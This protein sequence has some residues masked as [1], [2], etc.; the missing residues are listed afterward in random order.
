MKLKITKLWE[1]INGNCHLNKANLLQGNQFRFQS[2]IEPC[3]CRNLCQTGGS[4]QPT[5]QLYPPKRTRCT[6]ISHILKNLVMMG[7]QQWKKS[8]HISWVGY[9]SEQFACLRQALSLWSRF[10]KSMNI[11]SKHLPIKE[12]GLAKNQ[13]GNGWRK[14]Y[15]FSS[16]WTK[17]GNTTKSYRHC[18]PLQEK[19]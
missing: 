16:V 7:K 8:N 11:C 9:P 19:W 1:Y 3:R 6:T 5:F 17:G 12:R 15:I 4:R 10:I 14:F 18:W 2:V 13:Q